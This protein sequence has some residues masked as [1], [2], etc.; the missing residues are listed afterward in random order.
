MHL[1]V[2]AGRVQARIEED[3]GF[4]RQIS[5]KKSGPNDN[6]IGVAFE[7][8]F[9]EVDVEVDQFVLHSSYEA[10]LVGKDLVYGARKVRGFGDSLVWQVI[11][12]EY[13]YTRET[14]PQVIVQIDG[15]PALCT[16]LLCDFTY[17]EGASVVTAFT[18]SGRSLSITGDQLETPLK[19]EM[20]YLECSN[21][22]A[23]GSQITC[24]LEGDLPAGSW[25][26]V[27]TEAHGK[28]RVADN[29]AP[30]VVALVISSVAPK[31]TINP[32]GGDIVTITGNNFPPSLDARYEFFVTLGDGTRCI[33]F[34]ISPT[35][36]MCETEPFIT[37][38]R[39][40]RLAG[41]EPFDLIV[42]L[43]A[44]GG[45]V[46]ETDSGFRFRGQLP[47][48]L[49]LTPSRISPIA[50]RTIEIQ[51]DP[52]YPA[53]G[54]TT[55]DFEVSLHPAELELTRLDV[56]RE[57]VRQLN[58]VGVDPIQKTITVKYGGAYS[59]TY[60]L[61]IK[62][63]TQ[64]NILTEAVS[65]QVVFE[66]LDFT[67]KQGSIYGGTKITIQGGPFTAD[68]QETIV[69]V[70]YK[71]SDGIDHYCYVLS[72]SE[73]EVTCRLPL[74][75]NREAK[76][77]ELIIFSGTYEEG[78]CEM[79]N[80]CQ[81]TFIE[82][83]E[84]PEVTGEAAAVFDSAS[85]EYTIVIPVQGNTDAA[86]D[87]EF[88]LAGAPQ[89]IKSASATEVVVQVDSLESGLAPNTMDLYFPVGLPKGYPHLDAGVSFEPKLIALSSNEGSP[90]GSIIRAAVKGVG[91]ND[92]VTLFNAA[93][94]QDVCQS[95]KVT[96]YGVL[97]CMTV[98]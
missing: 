48:A 93:T 88:M 52:D 22:Q 38:S 57:G 4:K 56:L 15:M 54:M 83:D 53:A 55:D 68:L 71:W 13:F 69:K 32:A 29:V 11:P 70:G 17:Y 85:G 36:V 37:A 49:A 14:N 31:E 65:L 76:D 81:F 44:D 77:Y 27:V 91:I 26:P 40:R 75:L 45:P 98:A 59:G 24:D 28:V 1:G 95:A 20:G 50:F 67:P 80:A 30:K 51:L 21:V 82:V 3:C 7:I 47:R 10:P 87:I 62:S 39:R 94:G 23:T 42:G 2:G 89:T 18:L 46:E 74:D 61:R 5:V 58:V 43:S 63:K 72:V 86:E 92:S 35:Q 60:D 96:E 41:T 90:A 8:Y 12:G 34:D 79:N 16:G 9:N 6:G 25:Y 33:P 19:V 66:L 84:L 78:N 97:E 73:T 64:G